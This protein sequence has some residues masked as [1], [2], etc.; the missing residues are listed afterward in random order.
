MQTY[1][2]SCLKCGGERTIQIHKTVAGDRIDWLENQAPMPPTIVS[3]RERLDGEWGF[4]CV[5]GNNSLLTKQEAAT[6]SNPAA[7]HAQ[8]IEEI[9]KNLKV[10]KP[11][12]TMVA[13]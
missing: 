9:V 4:Q 2:V 5:C 1:K 11:T 7:P 10:E 12:F 6:F 13:A 3:G 8:E